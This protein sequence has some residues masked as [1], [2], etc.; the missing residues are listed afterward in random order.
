MGGGGGGGGAGEVR[1]GGAFEADEALVR[2]RGL[3][4]NFKADGTEKALL[5]LEDAVG[6]EASVSGS[7]T[8]VVKEQT[9]WGAAAPAFGLLIP[10]HGLCIYPLR[11]CLLGLMMV[12]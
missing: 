6:A 7:V 4:E 8:E 11:L 10:L 1:N 9:L 12:L 2:R 3:V 5:V